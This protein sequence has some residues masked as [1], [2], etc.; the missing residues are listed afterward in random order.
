[1]GMEHIIPIL[2]SLPIKMFHRIFSQMF[3][4]SLFLHQLYNLPFGSQ[5]VVTNKNKKIVN[6]NL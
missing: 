3:G 6:Q 5:D 1:M 2:I 4:K